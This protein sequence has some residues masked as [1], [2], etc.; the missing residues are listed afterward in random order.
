MGGLLIQKEKYQ[1][2]V[3]LDRNNLAIV[4]HSMIASVLVCQLLN[5]PD[6][7]CIPDIRTI[8]AFAS[9]LNL[10]SGS[11]GLQAHLCKKIR[12]EFFCEGDLLRKPRIFLYGVCINYS[13]QSFCLRDILTNLTSR[14]FFLNS[15]GKHFLVFPLVF[16]AGKPCVE[17]K[18]SS[19]SQLLNLASIIQETSDVYCVCN[20][21]HVV[22]VFPNNIQ[23]I[24][25]GRC[26]ID[27]NFFHYFFSFRKP[28]R[29][30]NLAHHPFEWCETI[31]D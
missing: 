25:R 15:A 21:K 13:A 3:Q 5:I 9:L 10:T 22:G 7:V 14:N 12:I 28:D 30:C 1:R 18:L 6:F 16:P 20:N 19:F 29:N 27:P 11:A 24:G 2:V 26:R 4:V 31:P 8:V 17:Y 23:Q